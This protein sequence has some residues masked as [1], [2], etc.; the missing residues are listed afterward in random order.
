MMG[1]FIKVVEVFSQTGYNLTAMHTNL[2]EAMFS[3]EFGSLK[4]VYSDR[5][6]AIMLLFVEGIQKSH[7]CSVPC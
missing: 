2:R 5:I 4:Y 1:T 3:P 7:V 6:K